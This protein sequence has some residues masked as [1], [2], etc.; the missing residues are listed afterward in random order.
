ML[1]IVAEKL[2]ELCSIVGWKVEHVSDES[3]Y[4]AEEIDEV[5]KVQPD[6]SLLLMVK[7]KRKEVK[8]N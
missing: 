3:G 5:L 8:K 4:L 6:F 1:Y 7:C 2:A